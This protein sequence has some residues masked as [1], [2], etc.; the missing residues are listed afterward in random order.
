M[1]DSVLVLN[2][3]PLW[4]RLMFRELGKFIPTTGVVLRTGEKAPSVSEHNLGIRP[5]WL[6][7]HFDIP[8]RSLGPLAAAYS[9]WLFRRLTKRFG[10][11]GWVVFT[12]PDQRCLC[13]Y[14]S[15]SRRIY[16]VTDDY[17][18]DYG[19]D[20]ATVESWEQTI[21][22]N[23]DRIVCVSNALAGSLAERL[24]AAKESIFISPNGLPASAIPDGSD[25]LSEWRHEGVEAQMHPVAGVLGTINGRIRL[26]WL[27]DLIDAL[28]WLN[29][30]LVGP[31]TTLSDEQIGDWSYLSGHSR[32]KVTGPVEY[33]E[34]FEYASGI[35]LG[36]IPL[37]NGGINPGCSPVRFFTQLPF[38]QPIIA[39]AG[40]QQ[41]QEFGPLV[42]IASTSLEF[43]RQ[44]E[45]LRSVNFDDGLSE[46]RRQ[47][48][49]N[50]T[51]EK[52]AE[53]FYRELTRA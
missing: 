42:S 8:R 16:Y 4:V 23:V 18:W 38:G 32:C 25:F 15:D 48:A 24:P 13:R 31:V 49:Q 53:N 34:M 11:P 2:A 47:A 19:W 1:G 39:S 3:R 41:L 36:L 27:R 17:R 44:V 37:A 14:F 22:K 46:E 40:C 7:E 10:R 9:F 12:S 5:G 28:P 21:V 45:A 52:R 29:L 26:D 51:W 50:H 43:I 33:H 6:L 20:A 30:I 35:D